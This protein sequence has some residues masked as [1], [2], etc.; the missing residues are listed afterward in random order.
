MLFI[1]FLP[2]GLTWNGLSGPTFPFW[3]F[4]DLVFR[5]EITK[6]SFRGWRYSVLGHKDLYGWMVSCCWSEWLHHRSGLSRGR[7]LAMRGRRPVVRGRRPPGWSPK[8]A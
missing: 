4:L 1:P 6:G 8:T 5:R 2:V 7:I 3:L